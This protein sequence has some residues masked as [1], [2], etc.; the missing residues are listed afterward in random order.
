MKKKF[1][2]LV[3]VICLIVPCMF[4]FSA[5]GKDTDDEY[6][7]VM[8]YSCTGLY[9]ME[10][11]SNRYTR[12]G[13]MVSGQ[14]KSETLTYSARDFSIRTAS[15][16]YQAFAFATMDLETRE[17]S[18]SYE[19]YVATGTKSAW[20]DENGIYEYHYVSME[21]LI[22]GTELTKNDIASL[23]YKGEEVCVIN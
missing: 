14:M 21:I 15:K 16:V 6:P 3:L 11:G 10:Q 2:S 13:V 12:I 7:E 23:Y 8:E 4:M 19:P 1:L 5:C 20:F 22:E 17:W 18:I 9:Y